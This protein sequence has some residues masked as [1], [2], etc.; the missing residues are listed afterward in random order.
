MLLVDPCSCYLLSAGASRQTAPSNKAI[1]WQDVRLFPHQEPQRLIDLVEG[2]HQRQQIP[3]GTVVDLRGLRFIIDEV[4][5]PQF[6]SFDPFDPTYE[7]LLIG[8]ALYSSLYSFYTLN[9]VASSGGTIEMSGETARKILFKKQLLE[10]DLGADRYNHCHTIGVFKRGIDSSNLTPARVVRVFEVMHSVEKNRREIR[11]KLD[12]EHYPFVKKGGIEL[13]AGTD[14]AANLSLGTN[15]EII[16]AGLDLRLGL[17]VAHSPSDVKGSD[18]KD[19]ERRI[20]MVVR[21]SEL[22]PGTYIVIGSY[23]L[24]G[25]DATKVRTAPSDDKE[26]YFYSYGKSL[27]RFLGHSSD[28]LPNDEITW[29]HTAIAAKKKVSERGRTLL[30]QWTDFQETPKNWGYVETIIATR[31]TPIEVFRAALKRIKE[32]LNG[33]TQGGLIID[34]R[35]FGR[36][37]R[38]DHDHASPSFSLHFKA[39]LKEAAAANILVYTVSRHTAAAINGRW[40]DRAKLSHRDFINKP[41]KLLPRFFSYEKAVVK[42]GWLLRYYTPE[43]A[44][45]LMSEN[46][47]GELLEDTDT[48]QDEFL[49]RGYPP[50]NPIKGTAVVVSFW[51]MKE[52]L[53]QDAV[54]GLLAETGPHRRNLYIYGWGDGN[55]PF[56]ADSIHEILD[57]AIRPK[58]LKTKQL[59]DHLK[60]IAKRLR[61]DPEWDLSK[62]AKNLVG[63]TENEF[64]LLRLVQ[65]LI[66]KLTPPERDQL[67]SGYYI[68]PQQLESLFRW[69]ATAITAS[70]QPL[71]GVGHEQIPILNEELAKRVVK[72]LLM[73]ANPMLYE[74]GHATDNGVKV[75]MRTQAFSSKAN[76]LL[77]ELGQMSYAV[78]VADETNRS[79]SRRIFIPKREKKLI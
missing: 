42:L 76:I 22:P 73:Q 39:L 38:K 79:W 43:H 44:A 60:L 30:A 10:K 64:T 50:N 26:G 12:A 25:A 2:F 6:S 9:A 33:S 48:L 35:F 69:Q 20:S 24:S 4:L 53:L 67:L 59:P 5:I 41:L 1:V 55:L 32:R 40:E 56:G 78:D 74:L 37:D 7:T 45:E 29:D 47:S 49:A 75:V 31:E 52:D 28:A 58:R 21:D 70:E 62:G 71:A 46:L 57:E 51:G 54:N 14:N 68:N 27:G 34:G 61:E 23:L 66:A 11:R 13:K 3:P 65:N 15:L 18:A 72:D 8:A 19:N 63:Q 36:E 17:A 77:Y 16:R